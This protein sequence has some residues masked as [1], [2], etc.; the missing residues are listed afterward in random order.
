MD[1]D[2]EIQ[3]PSHRHYQGSQL[4]PK[5]DHLVYTLNNPPDNKASYVLSWSPK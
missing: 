4:A 2:D 3:P 1:I 5:Y